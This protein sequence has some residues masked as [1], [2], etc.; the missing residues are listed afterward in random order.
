MCKEL[1][2]ATSSTRRVCFYAHQLAQ[3]LNV[4]AASNPAL[5]KTSSLCLTMYRPLERPSLKVRHKQRHHYYSA[6]TETIDKNPNTRKQQRCNPD[7]R[8]K[9]HRIRCRCINVSIAVDSLGNALL[10]AH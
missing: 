5:H 1:I 6:Q 2:T 3:S 10:K 8:S 4:N 9:N 7:F